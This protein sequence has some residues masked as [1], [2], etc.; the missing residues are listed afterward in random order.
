MD[1]IHDVTII[2]ISG[3]IFTFLAPVQYRKNYIITWY[4]MLFFIGQF[5]FFLAY[6]T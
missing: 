1:V 3:L 4:K 6:T 5:E 2:F